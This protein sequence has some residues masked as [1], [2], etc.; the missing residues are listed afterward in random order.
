MSANAVEREARGLGWTL[1]MAA[2]TI[3]TFS[4]SGWILVADAT[5]FRDGETQFVASVGLVAVII[6]WVILAAFGRAKHARWLKWSLIVPACIALTALLTWCDAA[7]R[8]G[9]AVSHSAMAEAAAN[10]ERPEALPSGRPLVGIKV[11]IYSFHS[12]DRD[13]QGIC[14]FRLLRNYPVVKSGFAFVPDNV[15][16]EQLSE[17]SEYVPLEGGWYYYQSLG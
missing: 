15:A 6:A 9:W 12:I 16:R 8:V 4:L 11:G 13:A 3:A 14:W 10:C 1:P 7:G 5:A 17:Y 2:E